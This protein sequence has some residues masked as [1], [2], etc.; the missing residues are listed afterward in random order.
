MVATVVPIFT[1]PIVP[2][3]I[4]AP[5]ASG[6]SHDLRFRRMWRLYLSYCEAGFEERRIGV[7]QMVMAKPAFSPAALGPAPP[8]ADEQ[9][10]PV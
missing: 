8:A 2:C 10:V 4:G 5:G 3:G 1:A 7:V 6:E 9:P